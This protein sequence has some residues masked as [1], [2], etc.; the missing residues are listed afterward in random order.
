MLDIFYI[1]ILTVF[2][3]ACALSLS[4]LEWYELLEIRFN[5]L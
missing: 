1:G 3:T 2:F 4:Q 5:K